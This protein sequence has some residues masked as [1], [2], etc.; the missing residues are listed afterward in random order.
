MQHQT[1]KIEHIFPT[2]RRREANSLRKRVDDILVAIAV[3][4][5]VA[6]IADGEA[7]LREIDTFTREFRRRFALSRNQS[8]KLIGIALGKIRL[9]NGAALLD[10]ACD[11]LN[12]HLD[13]SQKFGLFE[14]LSDVLI[15]D[16]RIHEGEEYFLEFV[17]QKLN[18]LKTLEKW[19]P[20]I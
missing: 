5:L 4:G 2:K 18:L 3:L 7:D 19:D 16:G 8:L 12:E 20:E 6:T 15:A 10:C 1:T 17:A 14:A 11:T 13:S 9:E